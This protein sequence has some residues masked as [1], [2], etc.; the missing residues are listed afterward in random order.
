MDVRKRVGGNLKLLRVAR[1][2]S[3]ERL[4]ADA[5]LE[6]RHVGAIERGEENPTVVTLDKL[7]AALG[8][9]VSELLKPLESRYQLP[10]G[11]RP[12]RRAQDVRKDPGAK[13]R[14]NTAVSSAIRNYIYED[15]RK[16]A[17]TIGVAIYQVAQ[18][19][20]RFEAAFL[21][22]RLESARRSGTSGNPPRGGGPD[23]HSSDIAEQLPPRPTPSALRGKLRK[24]EGAARRMLKALGVEDPKYALDGPDD[25]DLL[26]ALAAIPDVDEDM[27]NKATAGVGRLVE[28]I[29]AVRAAEL[30]EGAAKK[31]SVDVVRLGALIA[32]AG[33]RG[34]EPLT[35][36]V[37]A[38]AVLYQDLTGKK[39]GTSVGASGQRDEGKARG[40]FVNFVQAASRPLNVR[41]SPD[42]WRRRF[43]DVKRPR[44]R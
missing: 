11:L 4:A 23:G 40:P 32:P 41:Q 30:L 20:K 1:E 43:R 2:I 19:E 37:A 16:I 34:N 35:S 22:F 3:Q 27:I 12:G 25:W 42:A 24:T 14:S 36:W 29:E 21:W 18:E 9:D 38:M 26:E 10:A 17:R 33:H 44:S 6:R 31:A 15:Y 7:A 13:G 8:L 39:P 28:I 5:E